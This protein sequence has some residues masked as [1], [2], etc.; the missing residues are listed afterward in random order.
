[1]ALS[2]QFKAGLAM[3]M[4]SVIIGAMQPVVFRYGA[5][6]IDPLLY[7]AGASLGAG[8][9]ALVMLAIRGELAPLVSRRYAPRLIVLSISGTVI[10]GLT[11]AYGLHYL[12]AVAAVLLMQIEP[13]YSLILARLFAAERPAF[14]QL[15]A[16]GVILAGIG[17]VLFGQHASFTPLWA[18]AMLLA[19][20]L[21]WQIGHVISL[22]AMPPLSPICISGAR[23][24]YGGII[25]P[26]SLIAIDPRALG[27]LA[28]PTAIAVIIFTG[29][30]IYFCGALTWYGAISRLSLSWTTAIVVPGVPV[31]SIIFALLFLGERATIREMI[32]IAIAAGGVLG[33]IMLAPAERAGPE[34][35]EAIH[36]PL[37]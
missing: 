6:R 20:P 35:L 8:V 28:D 21:F 3:A 15:A 13:V 1:M 14:R 36:Q 10:T 5:T 7:C 19:T 29:V 17:S 24:I 16:T 4:G 12:G 33:L 27:G 25:L 37:V 23:Y 22:T 26:I 32:G 31:L 34:T 11:L 9:F 30:F 18:A 2:S